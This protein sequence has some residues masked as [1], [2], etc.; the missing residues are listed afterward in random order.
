[1]NSSIVNGKVQ[2][3]LYPVL[4]RTTEPVGNGWDY[5]I[6]FTA[7][8]TGTVVHIFSRGPNDKDCRLHNIEIGT[9]HDMW[10]E[11]DSFSVFDGI[12]QLYN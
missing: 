7:P 3:P 9:Y 12:I 10:G 1:M 6:L 2:K 4:K 5:V 11:A 8:R